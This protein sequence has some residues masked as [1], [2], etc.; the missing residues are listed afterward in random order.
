MFLKRA[1]D[2]RIVINPNSLAVTETLYHIWQVHLDEY[3]LNQ[4]QQDFQQAVVLQKALAP[5]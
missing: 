1:L 5:G 4:A 3:D 2:L